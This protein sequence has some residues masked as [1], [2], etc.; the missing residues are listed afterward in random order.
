MYRRTAEK[1]SRVEVEEEVH[2]L[3]NSED[4]TKPDIAMEDYEELEAIRRGQWSRVSKAGPVI[5]TLQIT[6]ELLVGHELEGHTI[7]HSMC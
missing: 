2:F 1:D 5:R 7:H 3:S 4:G 6:L